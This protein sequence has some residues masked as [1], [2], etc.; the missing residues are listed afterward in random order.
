MGDGYHLCDAGTVTDP[1]KHEGQMWWTI[2][3][4]S[5][6]LDGQGDPWYE[7]PDVPED[8]DEDLYDSELIGDVLIP[9]EAQRARWG[10]A[11]TTT[12]VVMS[13]DGQGFVSGTEYDHDPRAE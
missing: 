5:A 9:S 2:P 13:Q 6:V 12:H 10:L 7:D 11:D 4:W 8:E 3:A 1:G